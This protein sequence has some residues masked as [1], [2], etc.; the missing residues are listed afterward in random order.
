ML[1]FMFFIN[2]FAFA[3][4]DTYISHRWVNFMNKILE[5]IDL[6][7]LYSLCVVLNS[8]PK[9]LSNALQSFMNPELEL[10]D[11]FQLQC[12]KLLYNVVLICCISI[13]ISVWAFLLVFLLFLFIVEVHVVV[14]DWLPKVL[15]CRTLLNNSFVSW[16]LKLLSLDPGSSCLL[17]L[18]ALLIINY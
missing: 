4:C 5:I 11:I 17:T 1:A 6:M 12:N 7:F 14:F 15:S 10:R 16:L 8:D 13:Y 2:S 3:I 9:F 18:E